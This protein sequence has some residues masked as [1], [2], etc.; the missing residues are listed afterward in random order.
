MPPESGGI[1]GRLTSGLPLGCLQG[2]TEEVDIS[3]VS[4][5]RRMRATLASVSPR[6]CASTFRSDTGIVKCDASFSSFS[7]EGSVSER[8]SLLDL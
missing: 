7:C 3:R 5:W 6:R 8:K 2:G 1:C 4:S